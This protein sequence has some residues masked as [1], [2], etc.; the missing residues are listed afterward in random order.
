MIHGKHGA[1]SAVAVFGVILL[2]FPVFAGTNQ[3][4]VFST[5]RFRQNMEVG[6]TSLSIA[7]ESRGTA[8]AERA[9]LERGELHFTALKSYWVEAAHLRIASPGITSPGIASLGIASPASLGS[10]TVR[11]N[12]DG[13]VEVSAIDGAIHV[14]NGAGIELA[15]IFPGESLAFQVGANAPAK[16]DANG[17]LTRVDGRFFLTDATSNVKIEVRGSTLAKYLG[18]TVRITGNAVTGQPP[19]G[20][21]RIVDVVDVTDLGGGV[22]GAGTS[23][24]SHRGVIKGTVI[25]GVLVGGTSGGLYG[26]GVFDKG[27]VSPSKP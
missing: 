24:P 23:N 14:Q 19:A 7:P 18:R 15:R 5:G 27:Q 13:T 12:A 11:V 1:A 16:Y 4:S 21:A 6:S 26:A 8:S 25:G 20:V 3:E 17:C 22:C 10:A 2:V 9:I